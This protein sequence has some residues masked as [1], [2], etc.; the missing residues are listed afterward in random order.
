VEVRIG[1]FIHELEDAVASGNK[2]NIVS[3]ADSLETMIN[4]RN[5]QLKTYN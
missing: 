4:E 5:K 2:D 3:L 1:R